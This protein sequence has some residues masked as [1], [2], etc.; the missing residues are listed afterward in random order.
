MI[1]GQRASQEAIYDDIVDAAEDLH[2][3]VAVL[4]AYPPEVA[5]MLVNA[6]LKDGPIQGKRKRRLRGF[7]ANEVQALRTSRAEGNTI[8]F[9]EGRAEPGRAAA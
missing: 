3:V 4:A 5:A 7:I 1:E 9:E 6:A 2:R 8:T